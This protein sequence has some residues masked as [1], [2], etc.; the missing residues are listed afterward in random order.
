M[1][2]AEM[3]DRMTSAELTRWSVLFE[4]EAQER[5]DAKDRAESGDGIVNDPM[6]EDDTD[7][8]G[9]DEPAE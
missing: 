9:D 7:D 5:Q 8:D 2:E 6:R 1:T 4:V 3:L